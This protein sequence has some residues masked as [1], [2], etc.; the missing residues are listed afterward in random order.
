MISDDCKD[1][2]PTIFHSIK[3]TDLD[4]IIKLKNN[5]GDNE[6]YLVAPSLGITKMDDIKTKFG[7]IVFVTDPITLLYNRYHFKICDKYFKIQSQNTKNE[8]DNL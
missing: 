6:C 3:E 8:I 2:V 5:S 4:K 7:D 1:K